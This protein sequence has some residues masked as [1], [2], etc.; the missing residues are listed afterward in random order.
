ML[1]ARQLV[2]ALERIAVRPVDVRLVVDRLTGECKGNAYVEFASVADASYVV[3]GN[4]GSPPEV[5]VLDFRVSFEYAPSSVS[6]SRSEPDFDGDWLCTQCTAV[7]F[8]RRGQCYKCSVSRD[9][10]SKPAPAPAA[11]G[12]DGAEETSNVPYRVLIVR[13]LDP[14]T[15][16]DTLR[17]V[18]SSF[19]RVADLRLIRD[20]GARASRGFCFVELASTEEAEA[21]LRTIQGLRN[22]LTIDDHRVAASFSRGPERTPSTKSSELASSAIAA[23]MALAESSK[24]AEQAAAAEKAANPLANFFLDPQTG[25]YTNPATGYQYDPATQMWHDTARGL[26]Y[27]YDAL[28]AQYIPVTAEE[29]ERTASTLQAQKV[30]K[31][32]EKWQRKQQKSKEKQAEAKPAASASFIASVKPTDSSSVSA[33]ATPAAAPA[34]AM[35]SSALATVPAA[36]VPAAV[37][38]PATVP[39]LDPAVVR[40]ERTAEQIFDEAQRLAPPG[41]ADD[42]FAVAVHRRL[43][44]PETLVCHVCQRRLDA[45]EKLQRHVAESKLHATT[46]A[47]HRQQLLDCLTEEEVDSLEHQEREFNYRDRAAMRRQMYG[48]PEKPKDVP[49]PG[50][51]WLQRPVLKVEQPTKDGIKDDNKGNKMLQAMGWKEG[52]GLGARCQGIVAPVA[53]EKRAQGA[54]LGAAPVLDAATAGGSRRDLAM[55]VARARWA[56]EPSQPSAT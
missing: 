24:L 23:A 5:V 2:A 16:E 13:F 4:Q 10:H 21:M 6:A 15:T 51:W 52:Q 14:M 48:Q 19:G 47:A 27:R 45:V 18:F 34:T 55:S 25:R 38:I 22:P 11:T 54:G 17:R 44:D 37:P 28:Q 20:R 1:T 8:R 46:M 42:A 50:P 12:R 56:A 40:A 26:A 31:D 41:P 7:N 3:E 9:G 49:P 35:A 29:K 53:A 32:L 36:S 30:A 43:V 33:T 39:A